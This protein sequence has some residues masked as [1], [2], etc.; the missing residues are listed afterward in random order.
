MSHQYTNKDDGNNEASE[1]NIN[2]QANKDDKLKQVFEFISKNERILNKIFS[3]P[4]IKDFTSK[5]KRY[6]DI[7][8]IYPLTED[9][10]LSILYILDAPS[11]YNNYVKLY[12]Y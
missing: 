2:S 3:P 11:K 1:N 8:K 7:G 5:Y 9:N 12:L 10:V 6:K 4:W